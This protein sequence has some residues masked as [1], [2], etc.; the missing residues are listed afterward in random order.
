MATTHEYR[1]GRPPRD[2]D[3]PTLPVS[4]RLSVD[5]L[6]R[7]DRRRKKAPRSIAIRDALKSAGL[8]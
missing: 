6:A 2:G 4:F 7:L 5:E 8:I 3:E 1:T